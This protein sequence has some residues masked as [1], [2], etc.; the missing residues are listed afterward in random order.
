MS[1]TLIIPMNAL[2]AVRNFPDKNCAEISEGTDDIHHVFNNN[3]QYLPCNETAARAQK[4]TARGQTW[5][6]VTSF[7]D[8]RFLR[9]LLLLLL[10]E[11]V[12]GVVVAVHSRSCRAYSSRACR[13]LL[14]LFLFCFLGRLRLDGTKV[15]KTTARPLRGPSNNHE[16]VGGG[17]PRGVNVKSWRCEMN[18]VRAAAS[19]LIFFVY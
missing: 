15:N 3:R 17:S 9:V 1:G 2:L 14:L 12:L 11:A 16:S 10:I 6:G 19:S 4:Y 13:C 7:V 18:T 8:V 5:G